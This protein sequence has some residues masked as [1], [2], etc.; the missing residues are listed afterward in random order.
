VSQA[1]PV[2]LR[3]AGA[4]QLRVGES[5]VFELEHE[6]Q[7]QEGFLL[8]HGLGLF[9]YLNRCPHWSVDLDLGDGRFYAAD[10]DRIYCKNHGALFRVPDG[11]CDHGPCF[12]QALTPF[13]V[14]LDG[15]DAW[16]SSPEAR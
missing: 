2:R 15:D 1:R 7:K 6:G 12:G 10:V 3:V 4:R 5:Q 16:V 14:E 8:C 13:A 11:V 9:A